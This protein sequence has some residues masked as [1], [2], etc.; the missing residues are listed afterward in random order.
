MNR[1]W[2]ASLALVLSLHM[3]SALAQQTIPPLVETLEVRVINVDVVVTD[4]AGKPIKGLEMKDFEVFENG[5]PQTVTNFYEVSEAAG[6]LEAGAAPQPVAGSPSAAADRRPTSTPRKIIYF[7]DNLS[8][9]PLNRNHVFKTM[10]QFARESLRPGDEAMIATWNRSMKVRVPF[11]RDVAQIVQELD[12]ISR[13]SAF[14]VQNTSERRSAESRIRE[15]RSYEEA[16]STAR[17]YAQSVEHDL[18]QTVSALNGLLATLAG[19]EGKKILVLTSEGMPMSP[20]R[21]MFV[22]IDDVAREKTDWQSRGSSL[23][24]AMGFDSS[25]LVQSIGRSA[26]ANGI[27]LYPLHAGGLGAGMEGSAENSAPIGVGVQQAAISNSTDSLHLLADMTGGIATVG[28]NNFQRAFDRIEQDL[29][30]YY[31][32]GYRSS[33]ER[34]DRQRSVQVRVKNNKKYI[35]RSRRTFVEKSVPTEMNDRV[36][37]NLFYP[38]RANDMKIVVKTGLPVPRDNDIFKVPLEIH[39]PMESLTLIP[40]GEILSGGFSV[41]IGVANKDGDMSDI[42]QQSHRLTVPP[43][44]LEKAK[45]KDYVYSVDLLMEKGLNKISVGVVDEVSNTTGF[46]LR[47]L[48]VKDLR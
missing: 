16:I 20:G 41:Y 5:K 35:V 30:S 46:D 28:T 29:G 4:R 38:S 12:G 32:V 39:I 45:G 21:E 44:D 11:T 6:R 48:M 42:S 19:V 33:T 26:N 14:G 15:A 13:E 9:N 31:S 2:K 37:A 7:I 27:T 24:E 18:R 22:Y 23:M 10:K 34:V 17:S 1:P 43:G 47:R 36:I 40:Q 3:T 8:L 25:Q